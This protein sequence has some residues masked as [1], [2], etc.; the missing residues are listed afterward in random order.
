MLALHCCPLSGYASDVR[1]TSSV[2]STKNQ[3]HPIT[4]P[5]HRGPVMRRGSHG[6]S[7]TCTEIM[8]IRHRHMT[9]Q[10]MRGS[11]MARKGQAGSKIN[12]NLREYQRTKCL[13]RLYKGEDIRADSRY[14]PSQWE[15]ALL[16]ND[17]SYWLDASLESGLILGL[18]PANERR[19][20]FV[21]TSLIG[22]V[23]A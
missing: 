12:N 2:W 6:I 19:L 22:W 4:D 1:S 21:T 9:H 17:V 10:I 18:L 15:T 5:P 11:E 16:C 20:Y 23:Q 7:S 8:I 13:Q 14:A 3:M